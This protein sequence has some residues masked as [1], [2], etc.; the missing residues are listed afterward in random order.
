MSTLPKSVS[1]ISSERAV[2]KFAEAKEMDGG[3]F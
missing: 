2:G 3:S 1:D